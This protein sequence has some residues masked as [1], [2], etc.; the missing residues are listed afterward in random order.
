MVARGDHGAH[1]RQPDDPPHQQSRLCGRPDP[2]VDRHRRPTRRRSRYTRQESTARSTTIRERPGPSAIP[3][4][5]IPPSRRRNRDSVYSPSVRKSPQG[6][7][8]D[9]TWTGLKP[10]TYLLE[11]GTHP[12]IQASMGLIGSSGCDPAWCRLSGRWN[13]GSGKLQRRP[14]S[15][16]QRDRS[17]AKCRRHGGRQHG[18]FQ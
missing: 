5:V 13:Q 3:R 9:L 11:S 17:E 2:D 12:S 6:Q 14:A 16:F 1:Q 7:R 4:V 15:G 18:R 10:G 8:A